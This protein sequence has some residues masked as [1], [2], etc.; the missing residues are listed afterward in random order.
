MKEMHYDI[1]LSVYLDGELEPAVAAELEQHLSQCPHCQQ[2]LAQMRRVQHWTAQRPD[3]NVS[4]FFAGKVMARYRAAGQDNLW[5]GIAALLRPAL[6][7]AAVLTLVFV[8][9]LIW[10]DPRQLA[11]Q[12]AETSYYD[13]LQD[14]TELI[15]S[16]ATRDQVLQFALNHPLEQYGGK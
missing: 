11:V 4:P 1:Q 15:E 16:L 12:N 2:A 6:R 14:N 7:L 9:L 3:W 10:P 5:N 13:L 8:V